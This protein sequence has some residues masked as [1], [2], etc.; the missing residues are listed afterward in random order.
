M[1]RRLTEALLSVVYPDVCLVCGRVLVAGER[2][3]C[4]RC[5][6]DMP[7][8]GFHH[9]PEWNNLHERLMCHAPIHRATALFH[10]EKH[11]PYAS[12]IHRVKYSG[13]PSVGRRIARDYASQI[14]QTGFFDGVDA[15]QPVPLSLR[16][17]ISRGYNQSHA[18]AMGVADVAGEAA[19]TDLL[20]ARHHS[21]QTRKNAA[22]RLANARHTFFVSRK[23][24]PAPAH[25]LIVDD[26]IT[27]GATLAACAEAL[28]AAFP[29]SILSV[30]ALAATRLS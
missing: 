12:L 20:G 6:L 18:V 25:I 19:V 1:L 27:T 8:T 29:E 24:S 4:V 9:S 28:H 17:I 2:D 5:L 14:A 26:V 13:L 30:F 15:I 11:S 16:R 10:Y 22:D 23:I 7:H 21:S 3:I